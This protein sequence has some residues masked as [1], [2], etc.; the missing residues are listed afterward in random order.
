MSHPLSC[1]VLYIAFGDRYR[2]EAR[3]SIASL[4]RV[5]PD[6]QIAVVTDT[7]L[8]MPGVQDLLRPAI[9]SL[10]CKPTYIDCSP[11]DH[12]LFLDTDTFVAR[13]VRPLFGLLQHYDICAQFGGTQFNGPDGLDFQARACSGLLLFRKSQ[14]VDRLFQHWRE[15]YAVEKSVKDEQN[16]ADER[17]LTEA[18]AKSEARPGVISPCVHI[19]LNAPNVFHSP[20]V[21][22]HGRAPSLR[23]I[24]QRINSGWDNSTDWAPRVWLPNL[25]G[26]LPRGVRR[27][28]PLLAVAFV[29]R[30]AWNESLSRLAAK[31]GR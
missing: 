12:T 2:D 18:L 22:L 10:E 27:S 4:R 5:S 26:L 7:P 29:F 23:H 21:V 8:G 6:A 24:A 30:R 28:D 25:R 19:N 17:A 20:A 9:R 16:L 15:L 1:G 3:Q 13:D 31:L 14:P 11:F